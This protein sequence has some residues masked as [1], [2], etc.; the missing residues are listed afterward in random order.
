VTFSNRWLQVFAILIILLLLFA[1]C[2][3]EKGTPESDTRLENPADNGLWIPEDDPRFI[4]VI[5][6]FINIKSG[7]TNYGDYYEDFCP[8]YSDPEAS[9][10]VELFYFD[11]EEDHPGKTNWHQPGDIE[12][13][14]V[15]FDHPFHLR[16]VK[17]HLEGPGGPVMIR[18]HSDR[19]N[20]WP[21]TDDDLVDPFYLLISD[22][23]GWITIDLP[24]PGLFFMPHEHFWISYWHYHRSPY[25][26]QDKTNNYFF[27]NRFYSK[28]W[29][30]ENSPFV[31]GGPQWNY[32]VKA[33]GSY[34]CERES[35]YFTDVSADAGLDEEHYQ[36][37]AWTDVDGDLYDDV[38]LTMSGEDSFGLFLN[39]QAGAFTDITDSAGLNGGF[40][41]G[42]GVWGDLDNDGDLDLVVG[43]YVPW[44]DEDPAIPDPDFLSRSTVLLN[45][46]DNTFTEVVDSGL[47]VNESTTAAAALADFNGDGYLDLFMGA[48]LKVYPYAGST[49]DYLFM[50]NGDGTF[51]DVSDAA[52]IYS[53][54]NTPVYGVM[55]TD[56]D[57]DGD[58]DIFVSNYGRVVNRMW[59]NQG[60][61]TF[62]N[63]ASDIDLHSPRH[64]PGNTFGADFGDVNN[65]GYLDCFLAE[66]SHPRYQPS[67]E[68]SSLS[69]NGGPPDYLF[70]NITD[71]AGITCDEGEID[72]SFIDYDNDT[73]LDIFVSDL[74]SDHYCRLF[75]QND[76]GT[77][78][79]VSYLAGI[80]IHDCTNNG[81][82]DFD[83]DGDLDLMTTRRSDGYHV[84]LMRNDVGQDNNWATIRLTGTNA[85]TNAAAIGA[86]VALVSGSL[87]QI[88]EVQGG[89]GHASSQPSLSV[90]FGLADLAAVDQVRVLWPGGALE[91]W[92]GVEI[93]RFVHLVEGDATVYYDD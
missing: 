74:Y 82:A 69:Q 63:V 68:P 5:P 44:L 2:G 81:W 93:N 41:A 77:F 57:N 20:S 62:V 89:K 53:E 79:D 76:D 47:E 90:E 60:D 46:G 27:R 61:G 45:N 7:K 59:Q 42:F 34:F 28:T 49:P 25:L 14:H 64:S 23:A 80:E 31:W 50:G 72:I 84:H 3:E 56:Y 92:T 65:D 8:D 15:K 83:K 13:V 12:A 4:K 86:R 52:G 91:T 58:Q 88:R 18:I 66:I 85:T 35:T 73:L 38:L 87:T 17:M 19:C 10:D 24:E 54:N 32:M 67:S 6:D 29:A 21:Q 1:G 37:V 11:P 9:E 33:E 78:T 40:N 22:D 51:T 26:T 55:W 30:R 36:R 75:H 70:S 71:Q 48:W 16:A 43:V 39:D